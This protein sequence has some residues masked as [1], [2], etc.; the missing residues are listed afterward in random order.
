[1]SKLIE[2]MVSTLLDAR[3]A[4]YSGNPTMSD[5]DFDEMEGRLNSLDPNNDYFTIVGSTNEPDGDDVKHFIPMLSMQKLGPNADIEGWYRS[6]G[7][8][9]DTEILLEPKID[10]ISGSLVYTDGFLSYGTT[11]GD[12]K[13]GKFIKFVGKIDNPSIPK[14]IPH[15]GIVEVRGEFYIPVKL[16]LTNFKDKPL[17][18]CCSGILKSGEETEFVH[19]VAYQRNLISSNDNITSEL[20]ILNKLKSYGFKVLEGKI[21]K[22]PHDIVM[23]VKDYVDHGRDILEYETDGLVLTINDRILQQTVNSRRI[24]RSFNWYNIAIKPPSKTAKSKFLGI[25]LNVSKSGRLVPVLLFEPII[26]ANVEISRAT[27]DNYGFLKSF[28][29]FYVGNTVY[30]KRA[31]DVIPKVIGIDHDG[32]KNKR[33]MIDVNY[34]PSCGGVLNLVTNP[35]SNVSNLF[36]ENHNCPG[37]NISIIY[38][39]VERLDMKNVGYKFIELA[40]N[41][42]II[43]KIED[44]YDP[45]L[46]KKLGS[47]P[48]FVEGGNRIEKIITAIDKSTIGIT[49]IDII[50]AVGIP[51]IGKTTLENLNLV[52][53]DTLWDN[54]NSQKSLAVCEYIKNWLLIDK[55]LTTLKNLKGILKSQSSNVVLGNESV[56]ITG[57]F[58]IGRKEIEELLKKNGF[59]ISKA[60]SGETSYLLAGENAGSKLEKAK[61]LG[62]KIVTN[63]K[64]LIK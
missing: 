16:S 10:G 48:R 17:R 58:D 52:N 32:D 42:N 5:A 47:L 35:K 28:E 24:I 7:I 63:V 11:R 22:H 14:T 29:P 8:P 9:I 59:K 1:M 20:E 39:W 49:D 27:M 61:S 44:L 57:T 62:T 64:E 38:N 12:G 21:F 41:S 46:E 50:N 45:D 37:R 30:I 33:I 40:Y 3:E 53:I 60:V 34:C 19:F 54:V 15:K 25:E 56:C 6:C 51:G 31:N 2:E 23:F 36:C 26:I 43:T 4:Y 55:N 13:V 18:N